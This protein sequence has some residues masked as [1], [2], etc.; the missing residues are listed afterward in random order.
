[1]PQNL[2]FIITDQQRW[3]SLP[4]YGLDFMQ[5]PALDRLARE[6]MVF[7]NCVTPSPVCVPYRATMMCGQYPA[8]TGVL[9]N[10][11]WLPDTSVTWPERFGAAGIRTAAIGKMHF[12]PWDLMAGFD[13]RII[14][15]DKR[16]VY[17]PDDHVKFLRAHGMERFHPTE[18]PGY[19]E[20]LGASVTPRPRKFHIDAF[21]GDQAASWIQKNGKDPFAI[22]VSFPGPHDPYDPPEEMASMYYDAPIPEPI[23][24]PEEL[25]GKPPAQRRRNSGSLNNSMYRIDPS[26]TTPE[27]R[28]RWRAH[29]Y[30][31]I[32]L[33]DGGIGKM[34]D[35]LESVGALDDTLIV[36]NS[37]HGDALGDHGLCYK[38]FF[39]NAMV[40]TPLLIR[41]PG[42]PRGRR[43][44][45]LV[46]AIDLVPLFY[47]ACGI[48][49]PDTLEGVDITPLFR[50]PTATVQ[51]A[52]FSEISGRAM[53]QT[54]R[55]KYAHYSDGV[56]E[57]YDLQTDP[58]ELTNL[59]GRPEYAAVERDLRGRLLQHWLSHFPYQT[60]PISHPQHPARRW[61]ED[62]Y[63]K[64]R[65]SGGDIHTAPTHAPADV[66]GE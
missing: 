21:V 33:I 26:Q 64:H 31:N 11:Q 40:H 66:I 30:A 32:S 23:G 3:D 54:A 55:H 38:S 62:A 51:D 17:L 14:A 58:D 45:A 1:M 60:R 42:V 34:L 43:C 10:G 48:A 63:R 47:R 50:D 61:L 57:L 13:E 65:E 27:I 36:F 37:D 16:H 49:P 56:G 29:Y 12:T 46:N 24:S 28:R 59:A 6:G 53:V 19:F 2:L 8:T 18:K 9:G 22:W 41:G 4:C 39:Y 35:A 25:A 44:P 15:E 5:T 20:N 52:V 7:D